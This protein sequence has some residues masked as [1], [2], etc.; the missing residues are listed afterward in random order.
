MKV[1]YIVTR[2]DSLGGAQVHV[3]DLAQAL[4]ADGGQPVV[5]AGGD[6]PFAVELR[7]RNVPCIE[8][9]NLVRPVHPARDALAFAEIL[10]ALWRIAPDLVCA[11]TA[12]AGLLG[13]VAGAALGVPTVF[14]PHGCAIAG[15][16]SSRP[17]P[18]L[19]YLVR[20]A[21]LV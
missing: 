1:A 11:H 21:G 13:R 5:L 6:G 12:K 18:L 7:R 10:A 15:R 2:A 3:L 4:R 19:P 14:T 16:I 17:R 9:R 8:I 20:L